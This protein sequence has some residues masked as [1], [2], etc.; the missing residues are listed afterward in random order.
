[1]NN[2]PL[3]RQNN[4]VECVESLKR[5]R[6]FEGLQLVLDAFAQGVLS[7]DELRSKRE[8]IRRERDAFEQTLRPKPAPDNASLLVQA[9]LVVKA[10]LRFFHNRWCCW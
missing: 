1:M 4:I 7:V 8:A 3:I 10:A 2:R 5:D 9:W 6:D